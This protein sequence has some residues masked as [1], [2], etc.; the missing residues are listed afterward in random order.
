MFCDFPGDDVDIFDLSTANIVDKLS[1]AVGEG[2][3]IFL[4]QAVRS[5]SQVNKNLLI[6][7][8]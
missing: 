4:R 3:G 2:L 8:S 1:Q 7:D 6:C 5:S